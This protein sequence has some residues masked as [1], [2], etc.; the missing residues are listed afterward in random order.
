[1]L[2]PNQDPRAKELVSAIH[3]DQPPSSALRS[4][5][6][7]LLGQTAREDRIKFWKGKWNIPP[8]A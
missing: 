6:V 2:R 3:E 5:K 1:L 4:V 8:N 7:S